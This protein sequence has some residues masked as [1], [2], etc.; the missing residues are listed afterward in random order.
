MNHDTQRC[1]SST[2]LFSSTTFPPGFTSFKE[3]TYLKISFLS[4]LIV[5]V[6]SYAYYKYYKYSCS[7][8]AV[9]YIDRIFPEGARGGGGR[10]LFRADTSFPLSIRFTLRV[11]CKVGAPGIG[12]CVPPG[13]RIYA[14][15]IMKLAP[16]I[17]PLKIQYTFDNHDV[18]DVLTSFNRVPVGAVGDAALEDL[19]PR[20]RTR[21]LSR[22]HRRVL[23]RVRLRQVTEHNVVGAR[24]VE[25]STTTAGVVRVVGD[26]LA[27]VEVGGEHEGVVLQPP[28][29]VGRLRL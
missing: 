24:R 26:E 22:A 2:M 15:A 8:H 16:N 7:N 5:L 21:L 6:F 29:H 9:A 12:G 13:L 10:S 4:V 3:T 27:L 20:V 11:W 14:P 28:D 25:A 17:R 18:N 19:G 23:G 1:F